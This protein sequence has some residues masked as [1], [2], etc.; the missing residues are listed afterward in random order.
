MVSMTTTSITTM[1]MMWQ[2]IM[3]WFKIL[4]FS[5]MSYSRSLKDRLKTFFNFNLYFGNLLKRPMPT[6]L[7]LLWK[8]GTI[9]ES[10]CTKGSFR[11]IGRSFIPFVTMAQAS[12]IESVRKRTECNL[13]AGKFLIIFLIWIMIAVF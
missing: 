12:V 5:L 8:Y 6:L 9:F 2:K 1:T 4:V 10:C 3:E 11:V 13:N 7:E